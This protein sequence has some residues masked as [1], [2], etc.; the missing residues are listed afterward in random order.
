MTAVML[1]IQRTN[2]VGWQP[3]MDTFRYMSNLSSEELDYVYAMPRPDAIGKFNIF[4]TKLQDF[5]GVNV[6][7]LLTQQ[8]RNIIQAQYGGT[9]ERYVAPPPNIGGGGQSNIHVSAG[10][11]AIRRYIPTT[12]GN[13][14]IFTAPYGGTGSGSATVIEVYADDYLNILLASNTATGNNRFARVTLNVQAHQTYFIRIRNNG[15]NAIVHADL[16]ISRAPVNLALNGTADIQVSGLESSIFRFTPTTTGQYIFRTNPHGGGTQTTNRDSVLQVYSDDALTQ[17]VARSRYRAGTFPQTNA[18]LVAGTTYFITYSGYLGMPARARISIRNGYTATVNNHFDGG[19]LTRH[20]LTEATARTR[21]LGYQDIANEK[22]RDLVGLTIANNNVVLYQS[23]PDLCARP[24]APCAIHTPPCNNFAPPDP[25]TVAGTTVICTIHTPFCSERPTLRNDAFTR[26]PGSSV[27][28]SA[29]WS[30]NRIRS[31]R[32]DGDGNVVFDFNRSFSSGTH[33]FMLETG[34]DN[35]ITG[36]LIHELVHQYG[37]PD[38]YHEIRTRLNMVECVGGLI[39]S[40]TACAPNANGRD[41]RPASCIMNNSRPANVA[42]RAVHD[43]FCV[44]CEYD[45]RDH[46]IGHH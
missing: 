16:K 1:R 27:I 38:H 10:S 43:M 13:V 36:V 14:N 8:E 39:C 25:C 23:P 6:F 44:G 32:I 30:G 26:F 22:F 9:I 37:G 18:R 2:N 20:T 17:Q 45:M 3:F 4:M 7:N 12:S 29:I 34:T 33:I 35:N 15:G 31:E 41:P 40:N 11:Y 19:F 5:S 46:L 24:N 28:T 21:I 42:T